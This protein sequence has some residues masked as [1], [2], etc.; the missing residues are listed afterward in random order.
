MPVRARRTEREADQH[1]A[2]VCVLCIVSV[3]VSVCV[4]VCVCVVCFVDVVCVCVCVCVCL[5]DVFQLKCHHKKTKE[6]QLP[7]I[8][9]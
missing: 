7:G 9:L 3:S 4:C 6:Q 5:Y 8:D 2:M 1:G